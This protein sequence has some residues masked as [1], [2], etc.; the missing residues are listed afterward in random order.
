MNRTTAIFATS[1]V[2]A[3]ALRPANAEVNIDG[4]SGIIQIPTAEVVA[5]GGAVLSVARYMSIHLSAKGEAIA[6]SYTATIGYLPRLEIT[7]RG[8]DFPNVPDEAAQLVNFHD[9]S[10]S[11]KYQLFESGGWQAALGALDVGGESRKQDAYYGVVTYHTPGGGL[12]LSAGAG[13]DT[14]DGIFGGVRWAPSRHVSLLGEYDTEDFNY[15]LQ[16]HP[17]KGL[18]LTGGYAH[19]HAVFMASYSF[20]LDP[21]GKQTLCCPVQLERSTVEYG[22]LLAMCESVRDALVAESYENVLV[23]SDGDTLFIECESRRFVEQ[24]D[25]LAVAAITGATRCAGEI[26]EIV[27]TPKL[28]DVPQ[29]SVHVAVDDLLAFLADPAL[30]SDCF[31]VTTYHPGAYPFDTVFAA[32]ANKKPGHGEV[33]LRIVN[34]VA[35]GRAGQ[36]RY[37][38]SNGLGLGEE[39]F[40]ARGI[41]LRARQEWP[42]HNDITGKTDPVNRSAYLRYFDAWT[43]ELFLLGTTGYYGDDRYGFTGEAGYYFSGGRFKMGGRYAYISD[44][45]EGIGDSKDGMA[46]G[47]LAYFEPGLDL[48]LSTLSGQFL[49][50]DE[51]TLVQASRYFGP[52]E[53]TF[54]AFDTNRSRLHG[55]FRLFVPL[56]WYRQQRHGGWRAIPAPYYGYQY[57]SSSD[58]WGLLPLAGVDLARARK[59]LRPAYVAAHLDEFRRAAVLYFQ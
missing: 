49:E 50:G 41:S 35:G 43:P 29:L 2:L 32:E 5:D 48:E 9:R 8:V 30:S 55:G 58:R 6:R 34:S 13:S 27:L 52:T 23:G 36:A 17:V 42:F 28:E 11:A 3:L 22:S 51:G 57:R 4:V 53:L 19:E 15:A 40:L 39:I 31:L 38:T 59:G 14:L 18:G 25:A 54:F 56:P 20:P 46:L 21:R 1:L 44:R 37:R 7:A 33:Q 47:E 45:R 16:L 24:V 10:I 26:S 12:S